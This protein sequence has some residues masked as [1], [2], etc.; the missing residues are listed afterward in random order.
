MGGWQEDLHLP[1][2]EKG[3]FHLKVDNVNVRKLSFEKGI[4]TFEY[5]NDFKKRQDEYNLIVG[6][7]DLRKGISQ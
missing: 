4:W 6:F 5:D 2:N 1:D 3:E 7:S